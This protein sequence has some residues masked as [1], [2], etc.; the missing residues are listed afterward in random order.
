MISMARDRVI[1]RIRIEIITE[2]CG[3]ADQAQTV[4]HTFDLHPPS[5]AFHTILHKKWKK[6]H[7]KPYFPECSVKSSEGFRLHKAVV[8]HV[9][10]VP[11]VTECE[12]MCASETK[13]RCVTY[14]YKYSPQTRDNCLL[15]D[16]SMNHLDYYTDIEP[17][18]DYDIY[19]MADDPQMCSPNGLSQDRP[20][21]N[22]RNYSMWTL[23]LLNWNCHCSHSPCVCFR[24]LLPS[25]RF[26]SILQI[27]SSWFIDG[28][29][30][31]WVW[32]GMHQND[33]VYMPRILIS[34]N[35]LAVAWNGTF[36]STKPTR[37]CINFS[38][39]SDI[40]Q[41]QHPAASLTI[42]SWLIG[43]FV[44]WTRIGI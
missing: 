4:R 27:D 16:R 32:N 43:R 2:I 25:H 11:T 34:V 37:I 10:N 33:Q 28:A 7:S 12:R 19:S 8:S 3:R 1:K 15:C 23:I 39:S 41:K 13:F 9:Y 6:I 5:L 44:I 40:V 42:V 21:N 35:L 20:D 36:S 14:S 29:F 18:R 22:A 17:N 38:V 24:M 31:W 26:E 30:G